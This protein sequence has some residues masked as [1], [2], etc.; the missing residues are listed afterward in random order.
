[1]GGG[2]VGQGGEMGGGAE[3]SIRVCWLVTREGGQAWGG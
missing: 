2:G 1:M 3:S